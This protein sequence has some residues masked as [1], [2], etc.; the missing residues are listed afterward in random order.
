MVDILLAEDNP[1]DVRLALDA[2]GRWSPAPK[3]H[4]VG[5]GQ[6][7]IDFLRR[8]GAHKAAPRPDLVVLDIRMPKRSGF[9]VL[10]EVR[11]DAVL[12]DLLVAIV[13]TSDA[14]SD[15][16]RASGLRADAFCTK[17]AGPGGM[18]LVVAQLRDLVR[19]REARSAAKKPRAF[20]GTA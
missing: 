1:L 6:Q 11:D 15:V 9:E 7:A 16:E 12:K 8:Q 18:R 4:V 14:P 13:T 19:E 10:A 3:V 17:A 2:F 5:D 20:K